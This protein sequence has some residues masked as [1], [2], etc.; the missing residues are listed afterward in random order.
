MD[1]LKKNWRFHGNH[2]SLVT[3][4]FDIN[5]FLGGPLGT[6][7]VSHMFD[8]DIWKHYSMKLNVLYSTC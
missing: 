5:M 7:Y 3:V 8:I 2:G 6:L 4:K 1:N